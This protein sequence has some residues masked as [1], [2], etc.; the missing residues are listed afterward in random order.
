[1]VLETPKLVRLLFVT[2]PIS[3]PN[4]NIFLQTVLWRAINSHGSHRR[5]RNRKKK[6]P[7]APN[8]QFQ[9]SNQ[10]VDRL[11]ATSLDYSPI[12]R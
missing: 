9:F 1:M 5:K 8:K 10:S 7:L 2:T 12:W 3:V 4:F 11:N 6:I